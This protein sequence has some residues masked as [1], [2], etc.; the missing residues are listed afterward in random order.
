MLAAWLRCG[1]D[2]SDLPAGRS[3]ESGSD[4]APAGVAD[5]LQEYLEEECQISSLECIEGDGENGPQGDELEV[6]MQLQVTFDEAQM[7]D[8]EHDPSP[9]DEAVRELEQALRTHLEARYRVLY[10]EILDDAGTSCLLDV[11]EDDGDS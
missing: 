4:E 3:S 2:R 8:V 11:W 7:E 5:E 9:S 6:S 10:W 1:V